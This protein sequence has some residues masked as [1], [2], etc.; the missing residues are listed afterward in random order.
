MASR[1]DA[2]QLLGAVAAGLAFPTDALW[3]EAA[4]R[5]GHPDPLLARLC[6]LVIPATDTPGAVAAGV[7]AFV[8]VATLHGLKG[9]T[10]AL[11][12]AFDASL[13]ARAG[14]AFMALPH[15]RAVALLREVDEASFARGQTP[16]V[17]PDAAVRYW[18]TLKALILIGYYSSE[19]GAS[20]ELVYDLV[21][22]SFDPDVPL[23][24]QPRAFSSDWTGV[25]YA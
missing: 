3:A 22:G 1:R 25:K 14:G 19:I 6:D 15:D 5:S 24:T 18:P 7:P 23:S 8:A 13:D 2:L 12:Q 9:A 21:P 17:Q 4:A 20:Q 11:H 10:P 16:P